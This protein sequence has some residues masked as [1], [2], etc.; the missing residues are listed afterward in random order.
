MLLCSSRRIRVARAE[1]LTKLPL[2][3]WA[4][5]V[6]IH[7]AH[8]NGVYF[9]DSAGLCQQPWL[10]H[11]WQASDRIGREEVAIAIAQAE[12]DLEGYLGYRL[13][14]SWEVDEWT[15][16]TRPVRKDLVNLSGTDLRGFPSAVAADWGY[17][18]SGGIRQQSLITEGV[19]VAYTDSDGDDYDE[20]ATA[21]VTLPS[22]V[23]GCEVHLY[24]PGEAGADEWE[25]RPIAVDDSVTPA[26]VTFRREQAVLATLQPD[27][28][29]PAEDS[30]LRGVDGADDANFLTTIDAYRVYNDPQTQ[31]TFLWEPFG[32]GCSSCDTGCNLCAYSA[33]TGCLMLRDKPRLS[34]VSLRPGSWNATT[35]EFDSE[36]W[37]VG[38]LPEFARLYYYAGWRDKKLSC[39]TIRMDPEWERIVA[40]YAAALLDRPICECNNIKAWVQHWQRDLAIPGA[41]DALRASDADLDNPFGTRRGAVWAW[42]RVVRRGPKAAIGSAVL[43]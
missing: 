27:Y 1:T 40:Y 2:D 25:I 34:I 36:S 39:P 33:Q 43:I 8:F 10:Q 26:V 12:A 11:P 15:P 31:V 20:V 19:A 30:H 42:K 21:L 29:P 4:A 32:I 3:R 13:L 23:P 24:Y 6:G 22:G 41:D 28:F 18:V 9:G 38:R 14:P 5:I 37:T 7:P 16:T 35:L 17:M